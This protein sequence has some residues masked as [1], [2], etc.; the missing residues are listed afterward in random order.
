MH[1]ATIK[2]IYGGK[3]LT[4]LPGHFTAGKNRN[5]HC[6]GGWVG[7]RAGVDALEEGKI[8]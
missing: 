3:L 7:L 6:I 1:G 8:F 5:A 4:S 2:M